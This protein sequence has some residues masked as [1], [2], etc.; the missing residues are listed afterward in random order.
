MY[1]EGTAGSDCPGGYVNNDGL[2]SKNSQRR[3]VNRRKN[4]KNSKRK[5]KNKKYQG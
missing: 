1:K 3:R 5:N 2:C 4:K